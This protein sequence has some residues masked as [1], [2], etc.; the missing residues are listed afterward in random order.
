MKRCEHT[1][2]WLNIP[3]VAAHHFAKHP[4]DVVLCHN[5]GPRDCPV[6]AVK[7][8]QARN[9]ECRMKIDLLARTLHAR[10]VNGG[11]QLVERPET[12]I[13]QVFVLGE[14]HA[15]DRTVYTR[16][17]DR[18][19]HGRRDVCSLQHRLDRKLFFAFSLSGLEGRNMSL[20]N[21]EKTPT[22]EC[23]FGCGF[24]FV[25][26]V[27]SESGPALASI[28]DQATALSTIKD[29]KTVRT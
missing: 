2:G 18:H 1:G 19:L 26:S 28:C 16:V 6:L 17:G 20:K 15:K 14:C 4:A 21:F 12:R 7:D 25:Y 22:G 24:S 11:Q 9:F 29:L 8:P 23:H 5:L 3:R 13:A 10:T 27:D